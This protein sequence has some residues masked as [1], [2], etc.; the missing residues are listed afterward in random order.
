M[1][2][3]SLG[4]VEPFTSWLVGGSLRSVSTFVVHGDSLGL[5]GDGGKCLLLTGCRNLCN[6]KYLLKLE[7]I[8]ID[9][10]K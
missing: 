8:S 9:S 4:H 2:F 10:N 6:N 3:D 7:L 1:H 5:Y